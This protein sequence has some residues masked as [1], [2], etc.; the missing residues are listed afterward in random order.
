[1]TGKIQTLKQRIKDQKKEIEDAELEKRELYNQREHIDVLIENVH[2]S[3]ER[4][5]QFHIPKIKKVEEAIVKYKDELRQTDDLQVSVNAHIH[6]NEMEAKELEL[7]QERLTREFNI[8]MESMKETY[9]KLEGDIRKYHQKLLSL[10]STPQS[11]QTA[12]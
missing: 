3:I 2:N 10:V 12:H 5:D 8:E 11:A 1:M 9:A 4:Q 7:R 6:Q